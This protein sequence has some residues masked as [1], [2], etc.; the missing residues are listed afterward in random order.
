MKTTILFLVFGFALTVQQLSVNQS[1]HKAIKS[2]YKFSL[3]EYGLF[4]GDLNELNPTDRVIPYDL[5]TPLFSD[6][7][8]KKRFIYFP[9]GA[10]A[11]Y[12]PDR[13]FEFPIGTTILKTFYYL[14]D[15]RKPEKGKKLLET[16]VLIKETDGWVALPYI[17]DET[18]TD[19]YLEVAGG[20]QE[21]TWKDTNGKKKTINYNVP[22]M[23]QCKECHYYDKALVPIGPSA[24]QLN[25]EFQYKD[26]SKKNQLV[27]WSDK[28]YLADLPVLE[29][30]PELP[31]WQNEANFTLEERARAYLDA[32][33]GHCH[34][35]K[36]LAN[37]SGMFLDFHT[38]DPAKW[39]VQ[40]V[41]IA[42]GKGSGGRSYGIVPGKPNESILV[43][44]MESLNPGIMMPEVGRKLK[45]EEGIELIK[46]W[47]KSM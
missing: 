35:P 31:D 6:Y 32:N 38:K 47:I 30:V 3:S 45:H 15:E 42:A 29:E 11:K 39:G 16:R 21:V 41:P 24:R 20:T 36:G 44:R 25:K 34:H 27:Y 23:I 33:C 26:G 28:N 43:F 46:A 19:A 40:K 13:V 14:L 22:N 10:T 2:K 37:T 18:Q 9:E 7:T 12:Q 1:E 5:N 4:Q 17:W 8:H